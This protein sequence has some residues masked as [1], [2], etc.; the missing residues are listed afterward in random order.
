VQPVTFCNRCR[1]MRVGWNPRYLL[2]CLTCREWLSKSTKLLILTVVASVLALAFSTSSAFV[3]SNQS[4]EQ[5]IQEAGLQLPVVA[6][7][8]TTDPAVKAMESFLIA[9]KVD[10]ARRSRIAGAIVRTGRKYDVDPRLIA[11]IMIVE[12][13]ANPFAI[14]RA[15]SIGIMQIHVPT[16]GRKAEEE[17]IN[18]FKIEDNVEFGVRI[19]KEYIHRFG[20]WE[21]VKHYNGASPDSATSTQSVSEY[22]SRVQRIYGNLGT[23]IAETTFQ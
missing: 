8:V 19:L 18:L 1:G 20:L 9:Y 12:S 17:G 5:I 7:T 16:W 4:S 23:Q 22:V 11:S 2:H 13:R 21:G 15:D 3:F 14:S 10:R 6:K